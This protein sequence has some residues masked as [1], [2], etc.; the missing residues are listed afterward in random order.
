MNTTYHIKCD[1]DP[2]GCI[3][4]PTESLTIETEIN[5]DTYIGIFA[6]HGGP[7]EDQASRILAAHA[8]IPE[9]KPAGKYRWMGT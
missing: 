7:V 1:S 5:E 3:E 2:C 9:T 4:E 6:R 8:R